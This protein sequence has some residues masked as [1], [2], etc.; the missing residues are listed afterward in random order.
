[1]AGLELQNICKIWPD[2]R[3]SASLKVPKGKILSIAGPSG[4]GK[5]TLLGIAAG[6]EKPDSGRVLVDGRD[7]S[8]IGPRQRGIGMV[9]QD[10]ALFPHLDVEKNIA[11]GLKHRGLSG[12]EIKARVDNLLKSMELEGFEKRRPNMLSGGEKQRTALARSLATEP[13]IIL[14]DEALSSLDSQLRKRL[15]TDIV[16]EQRRLGFTAVYVSHDLEEAM[17]LGDLMA[18]MMNGEILQTAEPEKLWTD[19]ADARVARFM[20]SGPCLKVLSLK[21]EGHD[22]YAKTASGLFVLAAGQACPSL[23]NSGRLDPCQPYPADSYVFFERSAALPHAASSS[24]EAARLSAFE[25]RCIKKDFAGD[26]A[27]CLMEAGDEQFVLRFPLKMAPDIGTISSYTV[28]RA[29]L[30]AAR[31]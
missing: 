15:R 16:K 5:S 1:M 21:K 25:A 2:F 30:I 19:P 17:A 20:G 24:Q 10:Y 31:A 13:S 28:P 6:L 29:R 14:F 12:K 9:F 8:S 4:C 11:Y 26:A 22:L 27:D 7:V 23:T 3:L 18:I